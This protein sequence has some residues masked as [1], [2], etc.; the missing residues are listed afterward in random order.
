MMTP[1]VGRIVW[2]RGYGTIPE[3]QAL[4]AMITYV[5][6]DRL[7][8]LARWT[9]F[10]DPLPGESKVVLVQEGDPEPDGQFCHWMPYQKA[11]AKGEIPP[12]LHAESNKP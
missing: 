10:G 6:N 1:T 3:A 4:P 12:T 5:H 8:N 7:V 2:F 9:P 11:V